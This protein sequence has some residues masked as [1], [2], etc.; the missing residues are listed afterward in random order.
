M[1]KKN[2][3][4]TMIELLIVIVILGILSVIGLG[5]F[6]A[7]QVKSRDAN[8]KGSLSAIATSLEVYYNDYG[9]YPEDDSGGAGSGAGL[10][11]GCGVGGAQNCTY[12]S[13][14]QD[15]NNTTYM[16]ELPDD[17]SFNA[18]HYVS[19]G[20]EYKLYARLENTNDVS[21]VQYSGAGGV[22]SGLET[23]CGGE[24]CNYGI[25]ST[26]TTLGTAVAD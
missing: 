11:A 24:G 15:D 9:N 7:A 17:P 25:T 2:L 6:R 12:G 23:D 13:I 5:S 3:G 8:R 18:F 22:Y 4:F 26:N 16:V 21:A 20:T 10:I 1:K 14:W 19:D